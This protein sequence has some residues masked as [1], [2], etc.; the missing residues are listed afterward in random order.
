MIAVNA[1]A[2]FFAFPRDSGAPSC[3]G[4]FVFSI[5]TANLLADLPIRLQHLGCVL[6]ATRS[7]HLANARQRKLQAP[8]FQP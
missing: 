5:A 3:P 7:L 8:A 4:P 6:D 1:S 2:S